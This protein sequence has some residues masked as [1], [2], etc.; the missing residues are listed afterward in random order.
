MRL[1]QPLPPGAIDIIGD[2]HGEIEALEQLLIHLGYDS[3]GRHPA[4]RRLVFVGDFCD[5]GPD[6]PAVFSRVAQLV[7]A[8][9]AHAVLGNH[10]INLLRDD[11]KDGSGWYFDQRVERDQPKYA[12]FKRATQDQKSRIVEFVSTLPIALERADIRI[13]HAAWIPQWIAAI[14]S[15]Q[16]SELLPSFETWDQ[17]ADLYA[18]GLLN[19]LIEERQQWP[20]HLEDPLQRPPF[21]HARAQYDSVS[22]MMN[23]IKILTSGVE[24]EASAP[25]YISGKWRFLDRVKWWDDYADSI[26]VVIG[27]YWR[28]LHAG[29]DNQ[30]R[31]EAG[32]FD[33]IPAYSWHGQQ[34][35]VFCV[36]YSVGGRWS[37]RRPEG[38]SGSNFK[39]AALRWPERS[40]LFDDG[41]AVQTIGFG[42]EV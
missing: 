29:V 18:K 11:A 26:P 5:R 21:L 4:G 34:R 41:H 3:K 37:S 2:I 30:T 36:D 7:Q 8:G 42:N 24:R 32:L 38:G 20:H 25:F 33:D 10:E 31:G 19:K 27:H 12:P 17:A 15:I 13:I 14:R 23:P 39:L 35:N 28:R 1:I 16:V 9:H 22:Q 6:S 40:L